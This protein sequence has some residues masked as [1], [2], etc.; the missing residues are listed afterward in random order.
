MIKLIIFDLWKTLATI[1]NP[2]YHFSLLI[3]KEFKLKQYE[4]E[5]ISAFEK[6]VQ[7][8]YWETEFDSYNALAKNLGIK[9]TK[10]NTMKIL[11]VR[12]KAE[13]N[14]NIYKFAIPLLKQL[15]EKGYKTGLLTNSS[16]FIYRTIKENTKLLDYIDYPLFSFQVGTVKPDPIIYLEMQRIANLKNKEILMIGDTYSKDVQAPKELGWNAIHF[17]DDYN[18]LKEDLK[19]YAIEIK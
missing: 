4:D 8:K 5:I 11:A 2:L 18:K 13:A 15:R 3:K 19:K 1:A 9:P 12:D 16:I 14:I 17:K 6:T 10:E 7:T